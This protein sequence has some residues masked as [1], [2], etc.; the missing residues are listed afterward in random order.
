MADKCAECGAT[1]GAHYGTCSQAP[2]EMRKLF[3]ELDAEAAQRRTVVI[4]VRRQSKTDQIQRTLAGA[5]E[6][7]RRVAGGATING[8]Y[9]LSPEPALEAFKADLLLV[10]ADGQ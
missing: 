2:A 6:R 8:T 7:V 1:D 4:P 9:R 3:A 10:L 5:R